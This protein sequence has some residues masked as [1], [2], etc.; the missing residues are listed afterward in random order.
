MN[1]A[2]PSNRLDIEWIAMKAG[3]KPANRVSVEPRRADE[4]ESRLRRDGFAVARSA[5][6]VKFPGREP[7]TILY[8]APDERKAMALAAA[9]ARLLPSSD[10]KLPLDEEIALHTRFGELLGFPRCCVAEF[11]NRLRRGIT[12]RIDGGVADEDFVAAECAARASRRFLGRLNDLSPDRRA[13][14]VTFYPCRYDCPAASDYAAAVFA[15][16]AKMDATAAAE[17][18][19][20]LLG[21]MHIGVDGTRGDAAAAMPGSLRV[22]FTIF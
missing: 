4:V 8:V 19:A 3:V 15:A 22:D 12:C 2:S 14:I 18:R 9:E 10:A 16:A 20:A 21:E 11:C 13:R 6:A 17:L 7:S 1:R 5:G